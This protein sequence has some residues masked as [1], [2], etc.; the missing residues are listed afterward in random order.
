MKS[1]KMRMMTLV[2]SLCLVSSVALTGCGA[3]E[4]V[5]QTAADVA[6]TVSNA[7]AQLIEGD[8]TGRVGKEYTT[9][10][11]TFTVDSMETVASYDDYTAAEG[12]TL[13]V[14]HITEKNISGSSQPFGTFD[15]LV[16][17]DSLAEYIYPLDPFNGD[18]MPASFTLA[19]GEEASYDV[20]IEYSTSLANPFLMYMEVDDQGD[21]Y[22]SFKIYIN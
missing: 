3:G 22:T 14:A 16:D 21:T 5:Q 12:N 2:L 18:M 9:K 4:Q 10:W 8:V 11:F 19:D 15:W 6:E 17:D 1:L 13:L 7:A 20:V